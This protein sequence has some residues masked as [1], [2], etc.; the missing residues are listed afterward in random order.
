MTRFGA[1]SGRGTGQI[2]RGA[3]SLCWFREDQQGAARLKMCSSVTS[4]DGEL[5]P[6][7][8]QLDS[9]CAQKGCDMMLTST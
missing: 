8:M 6:K 3:G 4:Q 1:A 2:I 7:A 5:L 9:I